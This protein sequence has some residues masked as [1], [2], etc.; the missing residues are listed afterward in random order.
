MGLIPWWARLASR[1]PGLANGLAQSR[2]GSGILK[3]LGGIHP[4]R[5][6]PA[7]ARRTFRDGFAAKAGGLPHRPPLAGHLHQLLPAGDRPRGRRGA[8]GRRAPRRHPAPGPLLRPPALRLRHARSRPPPAPPDPG[9]PAAGDR[10]RAPHGGTGAELRGG[11]PGR[12]GQPVPGRRGRPAALRTDLHA[13]RVPRPRGIRAAP[14]ERRSAS[15]RGIAIT[16]R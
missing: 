12:I 8:G 3:K 16:T 2:A 1:F 10:G 6:L 11:V 15:S 9:G 14:P 5:R 4:D 13:R 7:L